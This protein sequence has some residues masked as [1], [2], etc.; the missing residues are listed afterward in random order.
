VEEHRLT[1]DFFE[2]STRIR[3]ED[4]NKGRFNDIVRGIRHGLGFSSKMPIASLLHPVYCLLRLQLSQLHSSTLA[5]DPE[6]TLSLECS[7]MQDP[8][9]LPACRRDIYTP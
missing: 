6:D 2:M 3:K 8:E 4:N 5:F 9:E 7:N 1:L